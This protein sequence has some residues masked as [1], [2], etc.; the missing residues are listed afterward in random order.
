MF[1]RPVHSQAPSRR[2]VFARMRKAAEGQPFPLAGVVG[3]LRARPPWLGR[4]RAK[5]PRRVA[6]RPVRPGELA[7]ACQLPDPQILVVRTRQRREERDEIVDISLGEG[8][9]LNILVEIRILQAITLVVLCTDAP[10]RLLRTVVKVRSCHQH[11]AQVRSL[12]G[13]SIGLPLRD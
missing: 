3:S 6:L 2:S 12:E 9:W 13:R 11:V 4:L 1:M 8:K 10:K 7:L 5:S